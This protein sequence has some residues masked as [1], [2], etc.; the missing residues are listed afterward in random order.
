[1]AN[2][3]A[4]KGPGRGWHGDAEGHRKAGKLGGQATARAHGP[5]FYENIGEKGG[6]N[7]PMQFKSG[8]E[9]TRA[10]GR[11]GGQNSGGRR[12]T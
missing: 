1:M 10:A 9:R 12:A 5:E 4:K 8:D 11:K 7:S 2:Q 6:Q 3:Q